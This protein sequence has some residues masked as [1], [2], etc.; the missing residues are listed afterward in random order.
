MV[1]KPLVVKE[2]KNEGRVVATLE[3]ATGNELWLVRNV[4]SNKSYNNKEGQPCLWF[5]ANIV[6]VAEES[7]VSYVVFRNNKTM[8]SAYIPLVQFLEGSSI[9]KHYSKK[10]Q[11]HETKYGY[12][13]PPEFLTPENTFQLK[14]EMFN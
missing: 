6:R 14:M 5:H 10:Y 9:E 11:G 3:L 2:F 13:T 1:T 12:P 4:T 7:G 8:I